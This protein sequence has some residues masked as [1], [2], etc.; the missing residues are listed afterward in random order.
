MNVK[1]Y[2]WATWDLGIPGG[3]EKH[4]FL[5]IYTDFVPNWLN[6]IDWHSQLKSLHMAINTKDHVS[7]LLQ[8]YQLYGYIL[9]RTIVLKNTMPDL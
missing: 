3:G 9:Y 1:I 6:F 8:K 4:S 7:F 2:I 5:H